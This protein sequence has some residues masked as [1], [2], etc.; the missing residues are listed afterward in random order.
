MGIITISR[1]YG[2]RGKEVGEILS[3]R[4]GYRI[5]AKN[6]IE[7][8]LAEI[9]GEPLTRGIVDEKVP[10]FIERLTS[11]L[12]VWESLITESILFHAKEGKVIILGRGAFNIFKNLPGS[13]NILVTGEFVQRVRHTAEKE[14]ITKLHAEEKIGRMDRERAGFIKYYYGVDWPDPSLFHLTINPLSTGIDES[15]SAVIPIIEVIAAKKYAEEEQSEQIDE[16]YGIAAI[17]NRFALAL[18]I[19]MDLFSIKVEKGKKV[20]LKFYGVAPELQ[21]KGISVAESFLPG[22]SVSRAT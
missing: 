6:E 7:R 11:D 12:R 22:Y 9:S 18:G 3:E 10:G 8:K 17:K 5:V 16:K 4:T 20:R 21:D 19:R 1:Q 2:A 13:L 14:K 15:V